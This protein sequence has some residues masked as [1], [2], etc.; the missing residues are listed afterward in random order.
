[1]FFILVTLARLYY[2]IDAVAMYLLKKP[3][4]LHFLNRSAGSMRNNIV[5]RNVRAFCFLE[6]FQQSRPLFRPD[7]TE[8]EILFSELV[9]RK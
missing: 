1:M 4:V 2:C 3:H 8:E 7:Q 6:K 5:K 9:E